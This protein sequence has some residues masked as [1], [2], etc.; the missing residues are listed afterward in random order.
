MLQIESFDWLHCFYFCIQVKIIILDSIAFHFR[1]DF[2]DMALRTRLLHGLVQSFMKMACEH[3]L[4]VSSMGLCVV[5][6]F[7]CFFSFLYET[8]TLLLSTLKMIMKFFMFKKQ[9]S[10]IQ[11]K[12]NLYTNLRFWFSVICQW[13]LVSNLLKQSIRLLKNFL[14][15]KDLQRRLCNMKPTGKKN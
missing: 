3:R 9:F 10:F 15:T 7:E 8:L 6:I 13:S 11:I 12:F 5:E 4:A 1:H 14:A 2:E